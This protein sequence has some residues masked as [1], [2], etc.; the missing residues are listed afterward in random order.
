MGT[1]DGRRFLAELELEIE[2]KYR[3]LARQE[4]E[5][6]LQEEADRLGR[7]SPLKRQSPGSLSQDE[8]ESA[9]NSG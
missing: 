2:A 6:R 1:E 3:E 9:D 7:T 5:R 8:G 4:L